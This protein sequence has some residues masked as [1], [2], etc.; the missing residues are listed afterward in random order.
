LIFIQGHQLVRPLVVHVGMRDHALRL[1]LEHGRDCGQGHAIL[2]GRQGLEVLAHDEVGL[3]GG[4]DL[5]RVD[6]R[7]AHLDGDV[8]AVLLVDAGGNRLVVAAVFGLRVPGSE[9]GD[10]VLRLG[11]AGR[12]SQCKRRQDLANEGRE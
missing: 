7:A 9:E 10:L 5:D 8:Q 1:H 4:D 2:D 11:Q 3:A 12:G 6:L